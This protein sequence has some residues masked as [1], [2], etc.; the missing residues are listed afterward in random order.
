M[1]GRK[2]L[3]ASSSRTKPCICPVKPTAA[4]LSPPM[5]AFSKTDLML[6]ATASHHSRGSCSDHRGRGVCNVC[7][8]DATAITS[9]YSSI[10]NALLLV[11]DV[12]IPRKN[13][14]VI[15]HCP[16]EQPPR[17]LQVIEYLGL[18]LQTSRVRYC[19]VSKICAEV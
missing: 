4:I 5:P 17:V 8:D 14:F 6:A 3:P 12:S 18:D 9:P 7:G 11:V 1:A 15:S 2:T 13:S 10:N 16:T 19:R